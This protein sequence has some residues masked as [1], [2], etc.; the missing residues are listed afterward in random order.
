MNYVG[1]LPLAPGDYQVH[2][3]VR[4]NLTGKIGSVI[5]FLKLD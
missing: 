5:A 4:D 3:V 2:L 1:L